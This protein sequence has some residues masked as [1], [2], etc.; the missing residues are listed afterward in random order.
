MVFRRMVACQVV[1]K[2]P[3]SLMGLCCYVR[4]Q[5]YIWAMLWIRDIVVRI[6]IRGSVPLTNG[7]GSGSC[8]FRP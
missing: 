4:F 8:Y 3:T 6:R 2:G 1:S 5:S 7:S